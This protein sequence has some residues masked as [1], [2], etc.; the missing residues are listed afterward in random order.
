MPIP[1]VRRSRHRPH[2]VLAIALAVLGLVA[3]ADVAR[4]QGREFAGTV[5]SIG[6]S[7]LTVE[8]RRGERV[9]FAKGDDTV[10]EGKGGWGA[11]ASGDRVIVKWSLADGPRRAQRVI[12]LGGR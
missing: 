11:L 12:V 2:L 6:G 10:V 4:A 1:A 5:V 8:D 3:S 9:T 7:S